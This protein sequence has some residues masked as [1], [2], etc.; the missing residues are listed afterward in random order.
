MTNDLLALAP[1]PFCN[2]MPYL[3]E[4][5]GQTPRDTRYSVHCDECEATHD[6]QSAEE[7]VT[8]WNR[9]T[10]S[11]R[12]PALDREALKRWFNNLPGDQGKEHW[13]ELLALLPAAPVEPEPVGKTWELSDWATAQIQGIED[14][15][16][17]AA[18]ASSKIIAGQDTPEPVGEVEPVAWQWRSIHG[19]PWYECS[20]QSFQQYQKHCGIETRPLY[21]APIPSP[22]A[23]VER[24]RGALEVFASV[25]NWR[26]G[27]PCDP[28]SPSF[29]GMGIASAALSSV[30]SPAPAGLSAEDKVYEGT[31]LIDAALLHSLWCYG[32]LRHVE[33]V[34][35]KGGSHRE[36]LDKVDA[37]FR[38][39]AAAIRSLSTSRE[40]A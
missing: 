2:G 38:D 33:G 19:G 12:A 28:N 39:R 9:R 7:A 8:A 5:Q 31:M 18:L 16:R 10:V 32:N 15:R 40:G 20:E 23:D 27:G 6:L 11:T 30:P 17:H 22:A 35:Y 21:A 3:H 14:N 13:D 26:L 1:C 4:Q 34:L 24:L 25:E 37:L 36:C 29:V